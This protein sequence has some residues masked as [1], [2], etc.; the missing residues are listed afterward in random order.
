MLILKW[1]S[2]K[3]TMLLKSSFSCNLKNMFLLPKRPT[4]YFCEHPQI[5]YSVSWRV[6]DAHSALDL[7]ANRGK[8]FLSQKSSPS[9]RR[10]SGCGFST[11]RIT[12]TTS[13]GLGGGNRWRGLRG[14][15]P[16]SWSTACPTTRPSR[17]LEMAECALRVWALATTS[18][19]SRFLRSRSATTGILKLLG[20]PPMNHTAF[21]PLTHL[22]WML[23]SQTRCSFPRTR[24]R[25]ATWCLHTLTPPR[26]Q[27]FSPKN[28]FPT[29]TATPSCIDTLPQFQSSPTKLQTFL[30][31]TWDATTL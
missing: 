8:P 22:L 19:V 24:R 5:T 14:W 29:T 25:T 20:A 10:P 7:Q 16:A 23:W 11:C 31:L 18:T 27:T 3:I 30:K 21:P 2:L 12:Q 9:W 26:W 17:C 15:T 6:T 1:M 13:T 28:T 4:G